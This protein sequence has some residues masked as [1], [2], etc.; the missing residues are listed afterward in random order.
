MQALNEIWAQVVLEEIQ[1]QES[2]KL[3]SAFINIFLELLAPKSFGPVQNKCRLLD[4]RFTESES[5]EVEA[6]IIYS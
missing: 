3:G 1:I 6:R 5:L 2:K 4:P